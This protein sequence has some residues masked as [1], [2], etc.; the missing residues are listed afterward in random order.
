MKAAF[1]AEKKKKNFTKDHSRKIW[2]KVIEEFNTG[3]GHKNKIL[4]LQG[5]FNQ[6]CKN[7]KSIAHLHD[8]S[9]KPVEASHGGLVSLQLRNRRSGSDLMGR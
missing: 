7:I 4:T 8:L 1:I 5:L 6:S 3:L 2:G 9:S